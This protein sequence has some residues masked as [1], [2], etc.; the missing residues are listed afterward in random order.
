MQILEIVLYSH[1]GRKRSVPFKL[2]RVNII[3]GRSSRGKSALMDI[4]DFCLGKSSSTIAAGRI[5]EST[6]WFGLLLQLRDSRLFV[7]R[8]NPDSG[9]STARGS[10]FIAQ[11]AS[12]ESPDV[13]PRATTTTD[14]LVEVLT[15]MLGIAPNLYTPPVG[16]T[17]RPMTATI[18]E[19]TRFC[20]QEQTEFAS[21]TS[22]F[23]TDDRPGFVSSHQLVDT[24]PYFLGAVRD[25]HLSI[26][27]ELREL[28]RELRL[29]ERADHERQQI[30]GEGSAKA[31]ALLHEAAQLGLTDAS[32][33]GLSFQE[34]KNRLEDVLK[35]RPSTVI[36]A[37]MGD[38]L[39]QLQ[40][41][42]FELGERKRLKAEEI[43]IAKTFA[44]E[45][46][47][48]GSAVAMQA[49]RLHAIGLFKSEGDTRSC[50]LCSNVLSVPIPAAAAIHAALE[51][52]SKNLASIARRRPHIH[53]HL[54]A[55]HA[56]L[57]QID[58]D[59]QS[60]RAEIEGIQSENAVASRLRDLNAQR[61]HVVGRVS[62]WIESIKVPEEAAIDTT[63]RR[64]IAARIEELS[65]LVDNESVSAR[66]EQITDEISKDITR[67]AKALELEHSEL[68]I[69]FRP[70]SGTIVFLR[71][72]QRTLKFNEIGGGY[73]WIGYHIAVHLALHRYFRIHGR[74]VPAFLFLDQPSQ[75][76]F[77]KD[78][79]PVMKG[80]ESFLKDD[81]RRKVHQLF[82]VVIAA[83][84]ELEPDLQVIVQEHADLRSP[85]FQDAVAHRW[86]DNGEALIPPDWPRAN[87][88]SGS[89]EEDSGS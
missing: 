31:S 37:A 32:P 50:P 62:L 72:G 5:M 64:E 6:S 44:G 4:V 82:K 53:D 77:P 30:L 23:H 8:M 86:G 41:K 40:N 18:R 42:M 61:A 19:A 49:Q 69:R 15:R 48:Y 28:Q 54:T 12:L 11:G 87:S 78:L 81:D 29:I 74:P 76:Q 65:N 16:Q 27:R 84:K 56:E 57:T 89:D 22:L 21:K 3:T 33:A 73:N 51:K 25:N 75:T 39:T 66:L 71:D 36:A 83:V 9:M 60:T 7:A 34:L 67:F 45:A 14:A 52:M 20:F 68:T 63:R 79:D 43:E 1:D 13:A 59:L 58:S 35:W 80:D 85:E 47:E 55:L 2:G 17:R 26:I 10:V 24:L 38:H 70:S 88:R 46:D